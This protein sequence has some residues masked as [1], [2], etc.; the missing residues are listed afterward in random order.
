MNKKKRE[1]ILFILIIA[2][3]IFTGMNSSQFFFRI[4]TTSE[5]AFTISDVSKNIF[6]EIPEKIHITYYISEKLSSVSQIP[7][8]VQDL[9]YEYS[10]YSR[11]KID[12]S[13][14][15]P[16]DKALQSQ[17]EELGIYPQ[18]IEVV[19][20]N[21]KTQALVYSGIVIEYLDTYEVLPFVFR[22]ETL[23]YDCT[24]R[25]R[26]LLKEEQKTL[27]ILLGNAAR[28]LN[29]EYSLL[30][31]QLSA[32]FTVL[33][34]RRS[35]E[36]PENIDALLVLGSK[37]LDDFDSYP[38]DQWLMKGG[39]AIFCVEG[40]DVDLQNNLE[41][42]S[43]GRSSLL[44]MLAH[45]GIYVNNDLVLD[46]FARNFRIP[47]QMFGNLAWQILGKY[48]YWIAVVNQNVSKNN[49]VTS[50]FTGVDLLWAS[51][52]NVNEVN[53]IQYDVLLK[54][55]DKA[56]TVNDNFNTNPYEA[57]VL[58]AL[59]EDKE[60]Q[61]NLACHASGNF[62]S[63]FSGREIP[64]R[65]GVERDLGKKLD[66]S[67]G[68]QIIVFGDS[69]FA[70][71]VIQYSDSTYNMIFIDNFA[72]WLSNDEDLLT[73]KTRFL[74]DTRLNK[75]LDPEKRQ[76]VYSFA[77]TINVFIIPLVIILF[78][79]QRYIRRRRLEVEE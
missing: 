9:L 20:R 67:T 1:I 42:K 11:G 31:Q 29:R 21:E 8:D 24:S 32:K 73:I 72:D 52:I 51:S 16:E 28:S 25:I 7:R 36:I 17:L 65:E 61:Y 57:Y 50:R 71:N 78:S 77:Q 3:V 56:W 15:H 41:P 76:R 74:R 30:Y 45:Y 54:T 49:I 18:Q 69:D 75:I 64:T 40:V 44:S 23:E 10:S 70:S 46:E 13:I 34:I 12:I 38:I 35:E 39:R 37:D 79:I 59:K 33:E 5:K 6:Q 66:E 68:T 27:G 58:A 63:Y 53:G 55:S 48:P 62:P 43:V 22:T 19:D 4:D 47:Q 14:I 2:I 26:K 60:G